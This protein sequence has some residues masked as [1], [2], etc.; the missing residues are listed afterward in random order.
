[1]AIVALSLGSNLG[2]RLSTL[3]PARDLLCR[4]FGSPRLSASKI[5]ETEPVDCPP[6]PWFLN[7]VVTLETDLPPAEALDLCLGVEESL[8]RVREI[9][10]GPRTLDVDLLFYGGI[11]LDTERL[12]L[13]HPALH[14]RRCIL[15][16]LAEVAPEWRHPVL[17][18]TVAQLLRE[19]R[20]EGVVRVAIEQESG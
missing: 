2:D 7:Q 14:L 3:A 18:K 1:M 12:T 13:P 17:G 5:Y 4:R 9:P 11:I 16:P 6:Q 19:C 8:G 15:V 10:K 20:D